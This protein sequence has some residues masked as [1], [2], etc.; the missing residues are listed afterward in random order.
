MHG[1]TSRRLELGPLVG[2]EDRP[3]RTNRKR[4]LRVRRARGLPVHEE[5]LHGALLVDELEDHQR[6]GHPER[7]DQG[8]HACVGTQS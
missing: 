3:P 2:D 7:D 8:P 5:H 4:A 6:L 1:S